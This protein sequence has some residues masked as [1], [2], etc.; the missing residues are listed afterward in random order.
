MIQQICMIVIR[1]TWLHSRPSCSGC[2]NLQRASVAFAKGIILWLTRRSFVVSKSQCRWRC[3][4]GSGTGRIRHRIAHVLIRPALLPNRHRNVDKLL[5]GWY[6]GFLHHLLAN[7]GYYSAVWYTIFINSRLLLRQDKYRRAITHTPTYWTKCKVNLTLDVN[8]VSGLPDFFISIF[9][10]PC[11]L[12][13]NCTLCLH[14]YWNYNNEMT[15]SSLSKSILP[16]IFPSCSDSHVPG[17]W[18][19]TPFPVVST[20]YDPP[21]RKVGV[22]ICSPSIALPLFRYRHLIWKSIRSS[23]HMPIIITVTRP[24]SIRR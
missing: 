6:D 14:V 16:L 23:C 21:D 18:H 11:S 13:G 20:S 17:S 5:Q 1:T 4:R 15:L 12:F 24:P 7:S 3:M 19:D 10:Q 2:C 22:R 9:I 8:P